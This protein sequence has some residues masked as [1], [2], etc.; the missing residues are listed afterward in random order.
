[1][2]ALWSRKFMFL[3]YPFGKKGCKVYDLET[4]EILISRE[5]VFH[6]DKFMAGVS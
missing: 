6:E 2:F 4:C 3:G 5:V 1:M